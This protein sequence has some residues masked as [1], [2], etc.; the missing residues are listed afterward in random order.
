MPS[1]LLT[2]VSALPRMKTQ[3]HEI[4][5]AENLVH[6]EAYERELLRQQ[7]ANHGN[8]Y[9]RSRPLHIERRYMTEPAVN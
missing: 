8:E 5:L 9:A 7:N 4:E 1:E 6:N 3:R 2:V